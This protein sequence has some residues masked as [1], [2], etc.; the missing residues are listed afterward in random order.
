MENHCLNSKMVCYYWL[1]VP[2]K[3]ACYLFS[4]NYKAIKGDAT[5]QLKGT[6]PFIQQAKLEWLNNHPDNLDEWDEW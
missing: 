1:W 4:I 3:S 2:C 5:L 6:L